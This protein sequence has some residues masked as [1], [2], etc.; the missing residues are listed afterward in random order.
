MLTSQGHEDQTYVVTGPE[1]LSYADVAERF[2]AVF[3][4][5]V[6]YQDMPEQAAKDQMLASGLTAWQAAGT[7][8][9]F[10]W[11]RGGGFDTVSSSVRELTGTDARPMGDWLGDMRGAFLSP[12][13][14]IPPS[15]F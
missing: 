5:Q 2:S 14:D 12:P 4:R 8:E 6:D 7:I 15:P 1:A 9:L 11:I 10:D 3:A 13:P